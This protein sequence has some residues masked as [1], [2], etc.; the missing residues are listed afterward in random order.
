VNADMPKAD[1]SGAWAEL[2]GYVIEAR[3][4]RAEFQAH[5]VAGVH[6]RAEEPL[7]DRPRS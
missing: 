6:D 3:D 5:E 7:R 4:D 1:W 2:Y